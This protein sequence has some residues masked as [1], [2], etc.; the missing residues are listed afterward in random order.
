M[1]LELVDLYSFGAE[2]CHITCQEHRLEVYVRV[3]GQPFAS[4]WIPVDPDRSQ[5]AVFQGRAITNTGR[6]LIGADLRLHS[7]L[8]QIFTDPL[9]TPGSAGL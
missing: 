3:P 2:S 6:P 7:A 8:V 9:Q 1:T 5:H 4:Q